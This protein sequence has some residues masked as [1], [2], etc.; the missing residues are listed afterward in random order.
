M[1]DYNSSA[2]ILLVYHSYSTFVENDYR[3]LSKHFGV[4]RFQ[5]R[6]KRDIPAL[7]RAVQKSDL[8][9]SWFASDH[10]A[11]SVF[12]SKLFRRQSVVVVGGGDVA[13]IPEI[14]YGTFA[15][16]Q[17]KQALT[18]FALKNADRVLVVDSSLKEDAVKNAGVGGGNICYVPTGYDPEYW[19]PSPDVVKEPIVL[20]VGTLNWSVAR[21][22]G[23]E[24]FVKA[25][26]MVRDARF[27][28]VGK[29]LDNSIE[30]LKRIAGPNVTFTDFVQRNELLNWYR[31]AR[32]YC[33]LSRY[34]GLP[35]AL[36]EA[37]LC[38]CIPIGTQYGGIGTAIG[39]T[40]FYVPYG[41][42]EA[43]AQAINDA[44]LRP[45]WGANARERIR[46]KFPLTLRSRQLRE[47]CESLMSRW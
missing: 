44:L 1:K 34:E 9:F 28:L 24:T 14:G 46:R 22:K 30:Y 7:A 38:E 23:Y 18:R 37:M 15:Q 17:V 13:C 43:T 26:S 11:V 12:F 16:S 8:T 32:V 21:R 40:G 20:T 27:V 5:W 47:H 10:A 19:K 41:D 45:E 42:E 36:C 25:A 35:N 39:D 33:Q 6:G 31:R 3:I 29:I 2:G 4:E